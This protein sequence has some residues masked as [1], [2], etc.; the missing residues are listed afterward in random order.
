MRIRMG[1][2]ATWIILGLLSFGV[3]ATCGGSDITPGRST[4]AGIGPVTGFGSVKLGDAVFSGDNAATI[5]DDLGRSIDDVV[6]GM[7][8]TV[9]GTLDRA[10]H[11]GTATSIA[12]EREVRGPVDDN[13]VALDNNTIRVLGQKVFVN[14]GTVMIRFS[15]GD[16]DLA[17]LKADLD[18]N[19]R[20]ELEVHGGV[21]AAGAIHA[22]FVGR[23]R[24]NVVAG[25]DVA[26]RGVISDFDRATSTFRIGGQT[27][28]YAGLP[29]GGRVNWPI[30][31]LANGLFAD[32]RGRIDAP[33]G[34]GTVRTDQSGDVIEIRTASLGKVQDRVQAEGYVVDGIASA[35]T[36]TVPNGTVSVVSGVA[37]TGGTFG[38]GQR[39]LV[40]GTVSGTSGTAMNASAV[41][42]RKTNDVLMEGSPDSSPSGTTMKLLGVA[43]EVDGL[44][45]FRDRT[46]AIR[47]N[48]GL[49]SLSTS[50]TV[51][52]VGTF[53]TTALP[54]TVIASKVERLAAVPA[55]S[56]TLQGPVSGPIG[57]PNLAIIGVTV[58]TDF[59]NTDY[60]GSGGIPITDQN[61]FFSELSVLGAGTVVR[62][63]GGTFSGGPPRIEPPTGGAR[64]EVE[65]VQV[66]N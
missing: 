11:T 39:V 17:A 46:G 34:A 18:N 61:V 3:L 40:K 29:S 26:F 1:R 51:R 66:N 31:G 2:K 59:A 48:F 38:A 54:G 62:A 33:G 14:P 10:F 57:S 36:M 13:G 63:S 55:S 25:D 52:V 60:F 28:N 45:L 32:V 49:S 35:F 27:V 6:E 42:V 44:T 24:D 58:R 65:F 4:G 16:T 22:T 53:D 7:V 9:R 12:I 41:T 64:M 47:R 37:P 8:V 15:G 5:T 23:G 50:D 56:A 20:P 21:D 43:V 30:T 19:L